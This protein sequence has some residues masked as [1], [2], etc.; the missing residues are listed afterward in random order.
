MGSDLKD[1]MQENS[2]YS[3][4][5]LKRRLLAEGVLKNEC[6]ICGMGGVWQGKPIVHVLDHINGINND[7]RPDNL[8]M[9]CRNCDSQLPT[10]TGRNTSRTR[11]VWT[12]GTCDVTV[13]KGSHRCRSCAKKELAV[14]KIQWPSAEDLAEEAAR[15]SYVAVG[16]RLGVSDNAVRKRIKTRSTK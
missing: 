12:C 13:S 11:K 15:T 5:N 7:H 16:R 10:F 8:R 1:M 6:A 14:F 2:N 4:G 9:V 3:R